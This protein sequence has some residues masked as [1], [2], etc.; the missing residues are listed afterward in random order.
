M[1]GPK[2]KRLP[3]RPI[4]PINEPPVWVTCRASAGCDGKM[5]KVVF[6]TKLPQGGTAIRYRCQTCN[7]AFHI[8]L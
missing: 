7:G 6:R 1:P 5:A 2:K 8:T 3:P 4:K